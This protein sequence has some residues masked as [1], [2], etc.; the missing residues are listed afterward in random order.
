M[1][2]GMRTSKSNS[3]LSA[4]MDLNRWFPIALAVRSCMGDLFG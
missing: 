3:L 2:S 4:V 1:T